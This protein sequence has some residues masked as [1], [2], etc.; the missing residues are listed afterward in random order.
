MVERNVIESVPDI[1]LTPR[2]LEQTVSWST[3]RKGPLSLR[4]FVASRVPKAAKALD[5]ENSKGVERVKKIS[6]LSEEELVETVCARLREGTNDARLAVVG[7]HDFSM[8]ELIDQVR[9]RT[10]LG[11]RLISST[12]RSIELLEQLVESGKINNGIEP[13]LSVKLP[14]FDF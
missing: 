7:E 12:K 4:E 6:E 11:R 5:I 3:E 2:A 8:D 13:K 10:E 1:R 9:I 14:D